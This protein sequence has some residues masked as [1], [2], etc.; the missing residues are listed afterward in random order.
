LSTGVVDINH[1]H[2]HV[3]IG[4]YAGALGQGISFGECM[5]GC[6]TPTIETRGASGHVVG[7]ETHWAI[8]NHSS[9]VPLMVR[10]ADRPA[11]RFTIS[12]GQG[13]TIVPFDIA[14]ILG[15]RGHVLTVLGPGPGA[16][17]CNAPCTGDIPVAWGL[18]PTTIYFRVM[19]TAVR[20]IIEGTSDPLP[21]PAQIARELGLTTRQLYDHLTHLCRLLKL[22]PAGDTSGPWRLAAVATYAREHPF[23]PPSRYA[24]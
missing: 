3:I 18:N 20:P 21:T 4:T 6:C 12:P 2:N 9:H 1:F 19:I 24:A 15:A 11:D 22:T 17:D 13:D 16:T 8:A 14:E 5:T 7:F 10:N 23:I